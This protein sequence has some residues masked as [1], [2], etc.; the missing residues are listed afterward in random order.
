MPKNTVYYSDDVVKSQGELRALGQGFRLN[1]PTA[2]R[3][4]IL[5]GYQ[6]T[7]TAPGYG[8]KGADR[9]LWEITSK[10]HAIASTLIA[11]FSDGMDVFVLGELP[12]IN[13]GVCYM[14]CIRVY[15][16]CTVCVCYIKVPDEVIT[17]TSM[18]VHVQVARVGKKSTSWPR[19]WLPQRD[20][21]SRGSTPLI[22][23]K[24]PL[25]FRSRAMG[26][27]SNTSPMA[28]RNGASS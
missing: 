2:P 25:P 10:M 4:G 21:N 28:S 22:L 9:S 27:R 19:T 11:N 24:V 18:S 16:V 12:P 7:G 3:P 26:G 8:T 6:N 14:Y 1:A 23:G 5:V 13:T 15:C 17:A 20:C